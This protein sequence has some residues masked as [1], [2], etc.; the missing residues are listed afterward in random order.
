MP[1]IVNDIS[2]QSWCLH[3]VPITLSQREWNWGYNPISSYWISLKLINYSW[4]I[5]CPNLVA[6]GRL[7]IEMVILIICHVNVWENWTPCF[8]QKCWSNRFVKSEINRQRYIFEPRHFLTF[9]RRSNNEY[10]NI[11]IIFPN[12]SYLSSSM[13]NQEYHISNIKYSKILSNHKR[14]ITMSWQNSISWPKR[15]NAKIYLRS[16]SSNWAEVYPA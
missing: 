10:M 1:K 8:D 15:D 5:Y 11:H 9:S 4:C 14:R 7:G 3:L 12:Q 2:Y 6:S 16:S 13:C